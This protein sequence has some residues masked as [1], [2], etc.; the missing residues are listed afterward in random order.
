[1]KAAVLHEASENPKLIVE[2]DI[3]IPDLKHGQVLVQVAYSGICRSQLMEVFGHRGED[4][5]LPH[6]LGHEGS[7]IVVDIGDGISKVNI[8]DKVI[9]GWIKGTGLDAGG[10]HYHKDDITINSGAIT[11]LNQYSVVSENRCVKIPEGVPMDVAVLFG[12]ALL[13]GG[14]IV[15]NEIK[16]HKGSTIAIIGLGGIGLSALMATQFFECEK[17][18][19]VDIEEDKLEIAKAFGATHCINSKKQ[20]PV[21]AIRSYTEGVGVDYSVE[22]G[23]L[24]S[25]IEQAFE[26]IRSKGGFCVFASHPKE[27][28]KIQIEPHAL[29]S[30]KQIRGSWG[31]ASQPDQDIPRFA[32]LYRKGKLPLEKLL[33]HRYKLD[34]INQAI[35]DL[36]QRKIIRALIEI[37]K[38][39]S[40]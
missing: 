10:C 9:L 39:L 4:R 13:T 19:A 8:G 7:G 37:D 30:G 15:F 28:E 17:V 36:K 33:S 31:G 29:I 14:G 25:T 5:Y 34:E 24:I 38:D 32:E 20:D 35:Q 23:G 12:C 18:I 26:A 27:G 2:N 11:T 1:M 40:K 22:A 3:K 16:P 6:L 21:E